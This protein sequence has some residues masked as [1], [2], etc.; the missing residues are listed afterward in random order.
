MSKKVG[1]DMSTF[2]ILP[3]FVYIKDVYGTFH[4]IVLIDTEIEI[5]ARLVTNKPEKEI[6]IY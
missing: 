6:E 5:K 2:T 1:K 4:Q 3:S